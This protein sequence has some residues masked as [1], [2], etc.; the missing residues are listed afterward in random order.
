MT[1]QLLEN[2]YYVGKAAEI[3]DLSALDSYSDKLIE[4]SADK[5]KYYTYRHNI[6]SACSELPHRIEVYEIAERKKY[7]E[8]NNLVVFQQW[9]ESGRD[10]DG[11]LKP[12][13]DFFRSVT[14]GI[15]SK[16]Y[17]ELTQKN[18]SYNDTFTLYEN[19]DFIKGH[20][21]G[22]QNIG[23]LCVILIYLSC[24][25]TYNDG[26]GR[27]CIFDT[28]TR[29]NIESVLPLR[30]NYV[31]IDFTKHDINHSVEVVKNNFKRFCYINFVY[32]SDLTKN[33]NDKK[34]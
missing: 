24:P 14:F 15:A 10:P 22:N 17:P 27:L 19:G 7:A 28:F 23:R 25:S 21:D 20:T 18:V 34:Y 2:G 29:L 30:G 6:D 33:E 11:Q 3:V 13:Q 31:L 4:L 12:I 26:G 16:I 5:S 9:Y 32:N 1:H 8:E